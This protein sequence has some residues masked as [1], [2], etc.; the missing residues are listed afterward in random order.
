MTVVHCDLSA[1]KEDV[2]LDLSWGSILFQSLF[3][4]ACATALA[5]AGRSGRRTEMGSQEDL[6]EFLKHVPA[7]ILT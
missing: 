3:I 7:I 5:L 4:R 2:W 1:I 6:E